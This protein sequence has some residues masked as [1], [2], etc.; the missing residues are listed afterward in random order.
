MGEKFFFAFLHRDRIDD[1][2]ALYA[3]K[4]CFE[5]LPFRA[6]NHNRHAGNIWLT[7]EELQVTR[8]S[9]DTVNQT[10]IHID[11]DNLRAIFD[12]L[13]RNGKSFVKITFDNEFLKPRR[14]RHIGTLADIDKLSCIHDLNGNL[15]RLKA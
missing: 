8:H 10:I 15:K 6:I 7:C 5:H 14:A 11:V 4:A 1:S 9:R 2:F 3:F 13:P 12:L